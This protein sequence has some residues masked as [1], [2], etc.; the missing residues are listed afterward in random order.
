MNRYHRRRQFQDGANVPMTVETRDRL[1]LQIRMAGE[2][3][4]GHPSIDA[5]NTLSKMLASLVRAGM[6]GH[7]VE[8][9]S[10]VMNLICDRYEQ[11]R[12]ITVEPEEAARLRRAI[13]DIDAGL[14]RVPLQRFERAVAEVEVFAAV[15]DPAPSNQ[16]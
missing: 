16:K 5:Y 14:H 12:V 6:S 9:G 3:L 10:A 7:L 13:A 15:T 11:S 1:A 8:S 4:I 2:S